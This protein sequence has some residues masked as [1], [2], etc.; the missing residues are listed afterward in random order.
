MKRCSV[1]TKRL[2]HK[3][4]FGRSFLR[5]QVSQPFSPVPGWD[6]TISFT[7]GEGNSTPPSD[8]PKPLQSKYSDLPSDYYIPRDPWFIRARLLK[9]GVT[10]PGVTM[11]A[12]SSRSDFGDLRRRVN[13]MNASLS[14]ED[15]AAIAAAVQGTSAEG[16]PSSAPDNIPP[17]RFSYGVWVFIDIQLYQIE[18]N[19]YMVDFKCDGYQ[20]V[21]RADGDGEWRPISKRYKNKPKE[22]TSPYPY[23]DVAS[24][25]IAQLAVAS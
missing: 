18:A 12:H 15:K 11:S 3:A 8:Q 16:S 1:C 7:D 23:L 20:N 22:V 21:I 24:D 2:P 14:A 6:L 10:A 25:L 5:G 13:L 9:E 17:M 4:V 19:N